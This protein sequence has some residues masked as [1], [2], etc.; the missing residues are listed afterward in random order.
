VFDPSCYGISA[1][2]VYEVLDKRQDLTVVVYE[3]TWHGRDVYVM[4]HP[5]QDPHKAKSMMELERD[6]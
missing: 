4:F 3:D 2:L 5:Q 1:E 6:M